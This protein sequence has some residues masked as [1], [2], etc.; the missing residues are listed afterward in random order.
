MILTTIGL[1]IFVI[2]LALRVMRLEKK[3]DRLAA[4]L[5]VRGL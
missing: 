3:L 1:V 2:F 4:R 5:P